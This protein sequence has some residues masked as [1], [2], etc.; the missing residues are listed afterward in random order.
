MTH[1]KRIILR[2]EKRNAQV[3][4]IDLTA[5]RLP[6]VLSVRLPV[7]FAS[8]TLTQACTTLDFFLSLSLSPARSLRDSCGFLFFSFF[9]SS[10]VARA[11]ACASRTLY[12]CCRL[13]V[14]TTVV[15]RT[16]SSPGVVGE[17]DDDMF[18]S[19]QITYDTNYIALVSLDR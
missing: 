9:V 13:N 8:Q 6:S 12:N 18:D 16:R 3:Q 11:L 4:Q 19:R 17:S 5:G 14:K 2:S 7:Q 1:V 10:V 15:R